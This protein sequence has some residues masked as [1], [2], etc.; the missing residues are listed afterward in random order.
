LELPIGLLI[1]L[2]TILILPRSENLT[3]LVIRNVTLLQRLH[4]PPFSSQTLNIDEIV[5]IYNGFILE[6]EHKMHKRR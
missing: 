1:D 6:R 2:P 5:E 3:N 4:L